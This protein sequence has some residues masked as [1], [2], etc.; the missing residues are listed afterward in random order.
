MVPEASWRYVV[1]EAISYSARFLIRTHSL[2]VLDE[3]NTE[4]IIERKQDV[5]YSVQEYT[6]SI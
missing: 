6:L 5:S 1:G 4:E 2:L 3:R